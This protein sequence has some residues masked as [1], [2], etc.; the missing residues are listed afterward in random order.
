MDRLSVA[1]EGVSRGSQSVPGFANLR[2]KRV[3]FYLGR[4]SQGVGHSILI[5]HLLPLRWTLR[6]F[7]IL[8]PKR[9]REVEILAVCSHGH[10]WKVLVRSDGD[11]ASGSL[12]SAALATRVD[13]PASS[14]RHSISIHELWLGEWIFALW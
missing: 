9:L 8:S 7:G 12:W 4:R 13:T 1:N 14:A 11:T 5:A 10:V 6:V 3:S 2:N